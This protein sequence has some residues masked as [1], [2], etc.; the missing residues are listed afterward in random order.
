MDGSPV[1]QR[2]ASMI[3]DRPD[4][5]MFRIDRSIYTDEAVS[6][7]EFENIFERG[8]VFL[9]HDSQVPGHGDYFAT[10]IGRQP[11]FVTRQEDGSLGCVI[12]ACSHRRAILTPLM[13]GNAKVITCRFLVCAYG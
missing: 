10:E 1:S 11:V 7:A 12:N 8:W 13:Q 6:R 3:D 4:D 2:F 9:C 5:G